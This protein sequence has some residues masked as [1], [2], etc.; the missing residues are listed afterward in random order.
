LKNKSS[1]LQEPPE[2]YW[3]PL[4]TTQIKSDWNKI[5][6]TTLS[7]HKWSIPTRTP[8][9]SLAITRVI[10]SNGELPKRFEILSST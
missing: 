10:H 2:L 5:R 9:H 7:Y 1:L 4:K 6:T 3:E 8:S